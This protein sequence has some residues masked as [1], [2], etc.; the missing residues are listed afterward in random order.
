M[1]SAGAGVV[2][3]CMSSDAAGWRDAIPDFG[4]FVSTVE[5]LVCVEIVLL[6]RL[7]STGAAKTT[8]FCG[9]PGYL[10]RRQTVERDR[11]GLCQGRERGSESRQKSR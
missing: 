1:Y 3:Y 2:C 9:T 7:N 8:T 4:W 10:A 6:I 5:S 11:E